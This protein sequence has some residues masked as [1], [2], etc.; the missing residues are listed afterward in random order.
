MAYRQTENINRIREVM[1]E[2]IDEPTITKALLLNNNDFE[3]TLN[4]ILEGNCE[5]Q[6]DQ[7]RQSITDAFT[8][9]PIKS[10]PW[11]SANHDWSQVPPDKPTQPDYGTH[12]I[13]DTT[14]EAR[15]PLV[16]PNSPPKGSYQPLTV[17]GQT[18]PTE[19]FRS[20]N[21]AF[22]LSSTST[23]NRLK[24]PM[25]TTTTAGQATG[26]Q[27]ITSK[28]SVDS[29][30]IQLIDDSPEKRYEAELNAAIEAS[31]AA[32]PALNKP[33][34]NIPNLDHPSASLKDLTA[35][36][37]QMS[38]ALEESLAMSGSRTLEADA[39]FSH[40][41]PS[42]RQRTPGT[43][44]AL[45]VHNP[46]LVFLPCLLSAMYAA[47]PFR[48]RIL[49]F[50][51]TPKVVHHQLIDHDLE[52][53][54]NGKS[55]WRSGENW[56]EKP[57]ASE[58]ILAVQRLFATMS[59]TK[60]A[61][62]DVQEL[63]LLLG[64]EEGEMISWSLNEPNKGCHRTYETIAEAWR[65]LASIKVN[66]PNNSDSIDQKLL[67]EYENELRLFHWK[68]HKLS[69]PL[70]EE[71]EEEE[72]T[73][74]EISKSTADNSTTSLTLNA[75]VESGSSLNEIYACIDAQVWLPEMGQA[76]FLDG[77]S[78]V[79]AFEIDRRSSSSSSSSFNGNGLFGDELKKPFALHPAFW[80][81]RYLLQNRHS[82]ARLRDEISRIE[83]EADVS[84]ARRNQLAMAGDKD[85]LSTLK[86]TIDYLS[87]ESQFLTPSLSEREKKKKE[88]LP[89]F[90]ESLA[91]LEAEL[92]SLDERAK[93]ALAEA[94]AV[95]DVDE[96]KRVGP[97]ELAAVVVSDG[98]SGREHMWTYI[99]ADDGRWF[100]SLDQS[101][102]EVS[103]DTVLSDPAGLHMN[104]GHIFAVY[105]LKPSSEDPVPADSLDI[106]LPSPLEEAIKKDNEL[107]GAE[108][109]EASTV[110][111]ENEYMGSNVVEDV[112][113]TGDSPR[114]D[115]ADAGGILDL[116]MVAD[117]GSPTFGPPLRLSGGA[118]SDLVDELSSSSESD[119]ENDDDLDLEEEERVELGFLQKISRP[120]DVRSMTGK[121]GGR[122]IWLDPENPLDPSLSV[123]SSCELPMKF[124]MQLN[125]P[126]DSNPAAYFRTLYVFI[127]P[128]FSCLKRSLN[129]PTLTSTSVVKVFRIQLPQL[130]P[131]ISPK[132]NNNK[133]KKKKNT[134]ARPPVPGVSDRTSFREWEIVCDLEPADL[135]VA[136]QLE[137]L[138]LKDQ[139]KNFELDS[140]KQ[141]KTTGIGSKGQ[142]D[143]D[144]S[145]K[146]TKALVD[147]GFLNFQARISRAPTQVLRYLRV[148][149][150]EIEPLW[151]TEFSP[152]Q[153]RESLSE[154]RICRRCGTQRTAEF[155][156]IPTLLSSLNHPSSSSPSSSSSSSV[157]EKESD[158]EE[159]D[160]KDCSKEEKQEEEEEMDFGTIVVF[161]CPRSCSSSDEDE[162]DDDDDSSRKSPPSLPP[163]TTLDNPALLSDSSLSSN[164]TSSCWTTEIAVVQT[165]SNHSVFPIAP[166]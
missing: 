16:L 61:Y 165:F 17:T 118:R 47:R 33:S 99:K 84:L 28:N 160:K 106:K 89:K 132:L 50:Q 35:E 20:S 32:D 138:G 115:V 21:Q 88:M 3:R 68:G 98:F 116:D 149:T 164:S 126:D 135:S 104:S 13:L 134:K 120:L 102:T 143:Q 156:I 11:P 26:S 148:K 87:V 140:K 141:P 127:C 97:H 83:G 152:L 117:G 14:N 2:S 131:S 96:M 6:Q 53:L 5:E 25:S 153:L 92:T 24:G 136:G 111:Q 31:L 45:R 110:F 101:V 19:D 44:T 40:P 58:I 112:E 49:R 162:D 18:T 121:V 71:D 155:Q 59:H 80:V 145:F 137:S 161:T 147:D 93:T 57:Q 9:T 157:Q 1:G 54:W 72:K 23:S 39:K 90:Q 70:P 34:Q 66:A 27:S 108:L 154:D 73:R 129:S 95:F 128:R 113:M 4:Y 65:E 15:E 67:L 55:S 52:G 36:D 64:Y 46:H 82:I 42:K 94:K 37:E 130:N 125:A 158:G 38:K 85:L 77:S 48:D 22:H 78:Q 62:L 7:L 107:F 122:P 100:K 63:S 8:T 146:E 139:Q 105:V 81:D 60:R 51:P 159:A 79:I 43:P 12:S 124:L 69:L 119:L 103:L 75:S 30:E 123:C 29:T 144:A 86:A 91:R 142:E 109:L 114:S 56:A 133:K 41:P 76:H 10:N 74:K 166:S 150:P 151:A 163:T